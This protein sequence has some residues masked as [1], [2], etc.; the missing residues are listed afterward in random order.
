M[1]PGT[2]VPASLVDIKVDLDHWQPRVDHTTDSAINLV[3]RIQARKLVDCKVGIAADEPASVEKPHPALNPVGDVNDA[4]TEIK[5]ADKDSSD[6]HK[7]DSASELVSVMSRVALE[8]QTNETSRDHDSLSSDDDT[9]SESTTE[10]WCEVDA[11]SQ[12]N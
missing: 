10:C 11:N 9:E 8:T 1:K 6:E 3:E 4:R 7:T 12:E 2:A 5:A